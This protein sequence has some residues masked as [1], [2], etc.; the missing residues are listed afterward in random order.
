MDAKQSE[1]NGYPLSRVE[2]GRPA[3]AG[4][5]CNRLLDELDLHVCVH[6]LDHDGLHRCTW[7]DRQWATA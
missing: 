5:C 3:L 4:V 7:C 2:D 1:A 6:R